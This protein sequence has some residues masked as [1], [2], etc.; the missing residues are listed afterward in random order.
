MNLNMLTWEPKHGSKTKGG[1]IG[2]TKESEEDMT[3]RNYELNNSDIR[4]D[5]RWKEEPRQYYLHAELGR[6][7]FKDWR[8]NTRRA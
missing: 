4:Q 1:V 3:L 7:N 2:V 5:K 8:H 6:A